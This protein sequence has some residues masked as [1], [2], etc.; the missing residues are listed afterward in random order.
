MKCKCSWMML[1]FECFASRR[2]LSRICFSLSLRSCQQAQR[3]STA[4]RT[5]ILEFVFTF[6]SLCLPPHSKQMCSNVSVSVLGFVWCICRSCSAARFA[7]EIRD[8]SKRE[9]CQLTGLAELRLPKIPCDFCAGLRETYTIA[10]Q[11]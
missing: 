5:T 8:S 9:S 4:L 3:I 6:Q 1:Y 11:N 7:L 2:S 10:I